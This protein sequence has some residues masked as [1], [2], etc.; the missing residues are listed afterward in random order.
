MWIFFWIICKPTSKANLYYNYCC[1]ANLGSRGSTSKKENGHHPITQ[2]VF[3]ACSS[4][5]RGQRK[6]ST[7]KYEVLVFHLVYNTMHITWKHV[8]TLGKAKREY[9]T[10]SIHIRSNAPSGTQDTI[11]RLVGVAFTLHGKKSTKVN[12]LWGGLRS[13]HKFSTYCS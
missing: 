12:H 4:R 8:S 1:C 6:R 11:G 13:K 5:H 10:R 2:G 3:G 7:C 9:L